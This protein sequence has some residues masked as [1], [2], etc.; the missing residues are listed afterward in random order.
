MFRTSTLTPSDHYQAN[1]E[2]ELDA[3]NLKLYN[4]EE[5]QGEILKDCF[6]KP[7]TGVKREFTEGFCLIAKI[8]YKNGLK[9]G[10][11]ETWYPE[12]GLEDKQRKEMRHY[13]QGLR[14]GQQY[15]WDE[16][17][18][19]IR[20]KTTRMLPVYVDKVPKSIEKQASFITDFF[21]HR[22]AKKV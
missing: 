21:S 22:N 9:H 12:K 11:Y 4:P 3:A 16:K 19:S 2:K 6:G 20:D 10:W 15:K 1:L 5:Y 17:G 13:Y 8:N 7:Y 14:E 18:N